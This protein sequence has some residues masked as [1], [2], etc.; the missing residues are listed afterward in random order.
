MDRLEFKVIDNIEEAKKIWE[1]F[2]PKKVID[3]EWNFRFCWFKYLEIPLHFIA[4]YDKGQPIGLLPLQMNTVKGLDARLLL[5]DKPFLEFFGGIDTDD[6][7]V[8][9]KP[10]FEHAV[11][12]F[13]RQI[14]E[15]A[16]FTSLANKHGDNGS[17]EHYLYRYELDFGNAKNID[18]FLQTFYT[19]KTKRDLLHRIR[20]MQ[21]E[22]K[23]EIH[24]G[25]DADLELLF[26]KSI[27]RFGD[28]S[29]FNLEY[30]RAIYKELKSLFDHD[31]FVINVDGEPKALAFCLIYKNSYTLLNVGYDYSDRDIGKLL[32][33]T[34]MQRAIEHGCTRFDAGQGDNGWKERFHLTKI[35]QYK[36]A[37][38]L[39]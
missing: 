29:S 34:E 32:V 36:L 5:M 22:H 15:P 27:E 39:A 3:D 9:V 1:L 8:F 11:P 14:K 6:N 37:L 13:F 4:G 33:V 16:I 12:Q 17:T 18:D 38:N 26:N 25:T 23:I 19:G 35:E 20:K 21:R 24:D 31:L 28:R 10:G 2:S 7:K 30:R